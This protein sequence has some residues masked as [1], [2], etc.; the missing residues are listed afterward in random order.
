M[1]THRYEVRRNTHM[2]FASSDFEQVRRFAL[3]IV[4]RANL[5]SVT[6]ADMFTGR[7]YSAK[8]A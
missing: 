2:V 8:V 7:T 5:S 4:D 3:S 1:N 6:I